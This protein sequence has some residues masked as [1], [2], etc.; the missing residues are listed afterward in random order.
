[1]NKKEKKMTNRQEKR[2]RTKMTNH[3]DGASK[4]GAKGSHS[5]CSL[6]LNE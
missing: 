6:E 5:S 2:M 4:L 1:M 3:E